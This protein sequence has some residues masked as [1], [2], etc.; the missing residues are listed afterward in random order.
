LPPAYQWEFQRRH[1]IYLTCWEKASAYLKKRIEKKAE[2][3][4]PPPEM[5]RLAALGVTG[6][7]PDPAKSADDLGLGEYA[8]LQ[9]ARP[10]TLRWL[11]Q[12]LLLAPEPAR[13]LIGRLLLEGGSEQDL[14]LL[15]NNDLDRELLG[16]IRFNPETSLEAIKEEVE[17]IVGRQ[18]QQLGLPGTR[19]SD[20]KLDGYLKV[21]DLREGWDQGRYDGTKECRLREIAT[22]TSAPIET[23][24]DRYKS[25]FRLLVGVEY[26][27]V[28]WWAWFGPLKTSRWYKWRVKAD[29]REIVGRQE[30]ANSQLGDG[31]VLE[32]AKSSGGYDDVAL[33]LDVEELMKKGLSDQ[34]IAVKLEIPFELVQY[35]RLHID[36]GL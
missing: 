3:E 32:N 25:A 22:K 8:G 13:K 10:L 20:G 5:K 1:P 24:K 4:P 23:V 7:C 29:R 28:T 15:R 27:P 36:D 30:V 35:L 34:E 33:R 2:G 16:V 14:R 21:W 18:K 19:R 11:A 17:K 26:D 6:W 31:K 9:A 12:P